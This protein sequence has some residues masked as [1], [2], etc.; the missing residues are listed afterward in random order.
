MRPL[1]LVLLA[2]CTP[3]AS[4]DPDDTSPGDTG[5]PDPVHL[6]ATGTAVEVCDAD[7]SAPYT[8][9]AA[10]VVGDSLELDVSHSCGCREHFFALCWDH[11]W[12]D[13]EPA[14][15]HVELLHD[16]NGETC[17]AGCLPT[18]SFSLTPVRNGEREVKVDVAGVEGELTYTW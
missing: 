17:E 3:P 13:V 18:L 8:V 7:D 4:S 15:V 6:T 10:R 14:I 16:A 5:P 2:A 1:I 9:T 12:L 11:S